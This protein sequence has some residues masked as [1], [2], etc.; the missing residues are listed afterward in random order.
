MNR[1]LDAYLLSK[2]L[3]TI[4]SGKLAKTFGN[5]IK[6]ST[7]SVKQHSP[8]RKSGEIFRCE[9]GKFSFS[10]TICDA[11]CETCPGIVDHI[12]SHFEQTLGTVAD[13]GMSD[14]PLLA[15]PEFIST[16]EL[17]SEVDVIE[18]PNTSNG[19]SHKVRNMKFQPKFTNGSSCS[20]SIKQTDES[21]PTTR[22]VRIIKRKRKEI[23]DAAGEV[24]NSAVTTKLVQ[25]GEISETKY[26]VDEELNSE[27]ST[28]IIRI[29]KRKRSNFEDVVDEESKSAPTMKVVHRGPSE[30]RCTGN[31]ESNS[32]PATKIVRIVKRKRSEKGHVAGKDSVAAPAITIT[33]QKCDEIKHNADGES[34]SV[35]MT[36]PADE[37]SSSVP[38]N[39]IVKVVKL[40]RIN[41]LP[42][43]KACTKSKVLGS[44]ASKSVSQIPEDLEKME[45][46]TELNIAAVD[47][48]SNESALNDTP[49]LNEADR[50]API[51][52]KNR[53]CCYQC[54]MEPR[55]YE[56]SDPRRHICLFCPIWFPNHID[57]ENHVQTVHSK[58]PNYVVC[59]EFY[60]YVCEK[61][62]DF[63]AYLS[64]HMKMHKETADF[65]CATCGSSFKTKSR[66]TEHMKKHEDQ[67]YICDECG[68]VFKQFARLRKHL[69]CHNTNLSFVCDICTKAFKMKRYLDLHMAV[70]KEATINCRYCDATFHFNSVRRA[71]E[72]SRHSVI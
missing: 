32:A 46:L 65:L 39:K 5:G 3:I 35:Q 51:R 29:I 12:N 52:S 25:R 67:T 66:L 17:K 56:P 27:P 54:E 45:T 18:P 26:S 9:N 58:D 11:V 1:K 7:S 10:C 68:K 64:G 50:P 60:C 30:I 22:V 72:K 19:I 6:K 69:W 33:E 36:L 37:D 71:H 62:F 55:I 31:E 61:R 63:R 15:Q 34:D 40:K 44:A 38:T 49:N 48:K 4:G 14:S 13:I 42:G 8:Q 16:G 43:S 53:S 59:K 41:F 20:K 47:T 24:L 23:R 70:H 21:N 2:S 28:K 57:F